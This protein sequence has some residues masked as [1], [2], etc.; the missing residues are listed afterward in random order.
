[1]STAELLADS[2][3]RSRRACPKRSISPN[4]R[5]VL[6]NVIVLGRGFDLTEKCGD[7]LVN[8]RE[9]EPLVCPQLSHSRRQFVAT[10]DWPKQRFG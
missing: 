10:G 1:M 3:G 7:G 4:R 9:G 6:Y 2:D 8:T 5:E